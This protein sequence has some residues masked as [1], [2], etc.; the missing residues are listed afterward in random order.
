MLAHSHAYGTWD[1]AGMLRS[2]IE[3]CIGQGLYVDWMLQ[4]DSTAPSLVQ[5]LLV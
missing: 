3:V 5:C 4:H 1:F 2:E